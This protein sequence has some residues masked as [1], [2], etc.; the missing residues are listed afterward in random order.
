MARNKGKA[1]GGHKPAQAPK[2][3]QGSASAPAE[4]ETSETTAPAAVPAPALAQQPAADAPAP[5]ADT[6]AAQ[7]APKVEV[8]LGSSTWPSLIPVGDTQVQLGDAVR[9]AFERM[10]VTVD[11]WN[12]LSDAERDREI[13]DWVERERQAAAAAAKKAA[14]EAGPLYR[15]FDTLSHADQNNPD[16]IEGEHL[17]K[18]GHRLGLSW[19]EMGRMSD[20]KVREQLRYIAYRQYER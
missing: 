8:L 1:A 14:E 9:G 5:A 15:P 7:D 19:S 6:S 13:G 20:H 3:P 10:S 12:A 2:Q 16:K 17:R 11:V 4:Q 18:L